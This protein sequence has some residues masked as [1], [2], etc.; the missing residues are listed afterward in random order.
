MKHIEW[1]SWAYFIAAVVAVTALTVIEDRIAYR[2]AEDHA[3]PPPVALTGANI[4][5]HE[6]SQALDGPTLLEIAKFVS[7]FLIF[8]LGRTFENR[9]TQRRLDVIED[10][11]NRQ[12]RRPGSD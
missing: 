2:A 7:P 3:V 8:V 4:E 9:D 12:D 10:R 5:E 11:L 6:P 1:P